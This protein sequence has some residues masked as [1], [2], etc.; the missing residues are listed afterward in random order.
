MGRA[1]AFGSCLRL[2]SSNSRTDQSAAS[3]FPICETERQGERQTM[4]PDLSVTPLSER[5]WRVL[6]ECPLMYAGRAPLTPRL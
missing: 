2:L 6:S 3:Y 1:L 5:L 4:F